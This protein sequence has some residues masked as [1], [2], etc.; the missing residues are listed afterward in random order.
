MM[1][2]L[3]VTLSIMTATPAITPVSEADL[4]S[5]IQALQDQQIPVAQL[6][7][8][9]RTA[10]DEGDHET[11]RAALAAARSQMTTPDPRV[12]FNEAVSAYNMGDYAAARDL[13]AEASESAQAGRNQELASAAAYNQGNAA[14]RHAMK[15]LEQP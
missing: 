2:I 10:L 6:L 14:H 7:R 3:V 4:P 12:T 9:A 8:E 11:A 5:R 13:F 15:S 1:N